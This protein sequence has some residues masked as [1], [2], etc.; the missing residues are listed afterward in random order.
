M[1]RII[2]L[3]MVPVVLVSGAVCQ[4]PETGVGPSRFPLLTRRY[5][6]K[7]DGFS[8]LLPSRP[9][10]TTSRVARK[11]GKEPTKRFLTITKDSVVYTIDV[12]E[13]LKP[14]QPL[15]EFIA[16]SNAG[17]KYDPAAERNLIVDGFPGKEYS[18]QTETTTTV[19]QF[20]ATKDRL[21][22]FAATGPAA[23]APLIKE[24]FSSIKL[25]DKTEGIDVSE[26][27]LEPETGDRIYSGKDVDVRAR[28]LTRPEPAYTKD[29]RDNK[30]EGTVIIR[31]VMS[32]TGR[33][34]NIKVFQSLPHGLTEQAI[35]AAREITFVPAAKN[36]KAVSTW[37]QLEYVFTL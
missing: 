25:G 15:E 26:P 17:V 34:E 28:F 6:V 27:P 31:A 22:R 23:A 18:S 2:L 13:N 35:K 4:E 24:F 14:E 16:E 10:L 11:D 32:K 29:A 37:I 19:M 7:G 12:V 36:G 5:T 21:F 33:I 20:L 8:V 3:L 1:K 30:I 9:A